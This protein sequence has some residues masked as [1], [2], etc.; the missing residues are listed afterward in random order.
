MKIR[1]DVV[2]PFERHRVFAAYRSDDRSQRI[3]VAL[4]RLRHLERDGVQRHVA[5]GHRRVPGRCGRQRKNH[6][7]EVP[8]GTRVELRGD[9]PID[10]SKVP[11]I[12]RFLR[13]TVAEMAE[14]MIVG[15]VEASLS[16]IA[17]GVGELFK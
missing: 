2:L 5:N 12:P 16:S 15:Q 6:D 10:G 14:K 4:D 7:I 11:A 13:K 17:R 8:G 9:L 1:A 3:D